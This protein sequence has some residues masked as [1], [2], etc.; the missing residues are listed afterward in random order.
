[1][2]VHFDC[3]SPVAAANP[4]YY[5]KIVKIIEN[6]GHSVAN[7]WD[8]NLYQEMAQS[9]PDQEDFEVLCAKT[10]DSL[11]RSDVVILDVRGK[12]VFGLGYQTALALQAEKPTLLLR[13]ADAR[14][15]FVDGLRHPLLT[16][17]YDEK[18]FEKTLS[19]FFHK[20]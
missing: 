11:L 4:G 20:V 5:K 10:V 1:M 16:H 14:G 7:T 12:G 18:D 9:L 19:W 8:D 15:S 17:I 6:L 13:Y 3:A 2:I